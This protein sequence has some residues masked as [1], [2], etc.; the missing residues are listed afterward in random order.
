MLLKAVEISV[1]VAVEEA[2]SILCSV[3]NV[4]SWT[5]KVGIEDAAIESVV[6]SFTVPEVVLVVSDSDNVENCGVA[7]LVNRLLLD[8]LNTPSG[9]TLVWPKSVGVVSDIS[10]N[11]NDDVSNAS[12]SWS[13]DAWVVNS[14]SGDVANVSQELASAV[15]VG[16]VSSL[17][18]E[19]SVETSALEVESVPK[20][21]VE[22]KVAV[23]SVKP[24]ELSPFVVHPV[25]SMVWPVDISS[26]GKVPAVVKPSET[27]SDVESV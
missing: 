16:V 2:G 14:D 13:S 9:P 10:I 19:L 12:S 17:L 26:V 25:A 15:I 20:P 6:M 4:V 8:E 24:V 7:G 11:V 18:V 3:G 21:S 5:S 23:V 22:R 1:V 27:A